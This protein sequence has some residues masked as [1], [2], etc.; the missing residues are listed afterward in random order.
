[1]TDK[2]RAK[3]KDEILNR[4]QGSEKDCE[5]LSREMDSDFDFIWTLTEE[6]NF[7]GH[8]MTRDYSTK[9]GPGKAVQL[10][11]KGRTFAKTSS[12]SFLLESEKSTLKSRQRSKIT[13]TVISIGLSIIFGLSTAILG[14][15]TFSRDQTIN[16]QQTEIHKLESQ[17]DSLKKVL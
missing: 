10:T 2:E 6:M 12:Y 5:K 9:N 13:L 3:L 11:P 7:E 16:K 1:M 15:L 14:W 4:L 8:L 17:I